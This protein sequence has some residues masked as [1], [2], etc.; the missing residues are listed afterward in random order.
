MEKFQVISKDELYKT[1]G[2]F[3]TTLPVFWPTKI[4]TWIANNWK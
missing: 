3:M 4:V 1:A 2:G